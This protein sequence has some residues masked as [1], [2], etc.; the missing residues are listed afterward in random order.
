M[1][2]SA[3]DRHADAELARAFRDRLC[4]QAVE[5]DRGQDEREPA[6]HGEHP[7][8]YAAVAQRAIDARLKCSRVLIGSVG[9]TS[10][11]AASTRWATSPSGSGD[12]TS[13]VADRTAELRTGERQV[14]EQFRILRH[15]LPMDVG[16]HANDGE[17]LRRTR[18]CLWNDDAPANR[19]GVAEQ[20]ARQ[21]LAD[22]GR[23]RCTGRRQRLRVREGAAL[24]NRMPRTSKYARLTAFA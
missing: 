17:L 10:F 2:P 15:A 13:S 14:E 21:L 16:S 1:R 22:N 9:S 5:T 8:E 12:L 23:G 19:I 24:D 20:P 11:A 6:K 3:A 18:G 4:Q 7:R